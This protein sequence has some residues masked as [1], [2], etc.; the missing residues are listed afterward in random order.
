MVV[1]VRILQFVVVLLLDL[2]EKALAMEQERVGGIPKFHRHD[3]ELIVNHGAPGNRSANRNEMIAPL[4]NESDVPCG[5]QTHNQ[6]GAEECSS[7]AGPCE[8][9]AVKQ[10][11]KPDDKCR[12]EALFLTTNASSSEM[13]TIISPF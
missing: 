9:D 4:K 6:C 11:G 3:A 13:S 12:S 1:R 10:R 5:K 7:F 2:M 8:S